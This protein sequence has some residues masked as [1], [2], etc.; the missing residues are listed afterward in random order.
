[1]KE[2][3]KI[4]M[5]GGSLKVTAKSLRNYH[6]SDKLIISFDH[7]I[8]TIWGKP[9][10]SERPNPADG[11]PEVT[12]DSHES[13]HVASLMRVNHAGEVSAQA[14]YQGQAVTA[15]LSHIRSTMERAALEEYDHLVWCEKRLDEVGSHKSYLNFF[16]YSGSFAIGAIAGM[17]GDQWSLGFVIETE[18]QVIAHLEDH[19]AR[20]PA[21]DMKSRAIL[22]QMQEDEAH[23]A[24]VALHAGG[25]E[26]LP[27]PIK[28]IMGL[29]SKVMT[30]TAYYF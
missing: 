23:H 15:K 25:V 10:Q 21:H 2:T 24:T 19:V 20:L 8:R 30:A 1:M 6:I 17:I 3:S 26:H 14:L 16:W 27:M 9:W 11:I 4:G 13:R 18:R 29:T 5:V 7:A 12:L 28:T 22:L